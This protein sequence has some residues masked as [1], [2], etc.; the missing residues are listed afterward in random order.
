MMPLDGSK[1]SEIIRE[2][3]LLLLSGGEVSSALEIVR[4]QVWRSHRACY[5]HSGGGVHVAAVE[6]R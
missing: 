5:L 1:A 4:K 3:L 6:E 2:E